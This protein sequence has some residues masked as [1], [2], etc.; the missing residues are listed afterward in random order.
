LLILS[1][2]SRR[3]WRPL[4]S[5]LRAHVEVVRADELEH[6]VVFDCAGLLLAE[7]VPVYQFWKEDLDFLESEVEANTHPLAS[8]KRNVCCLVSVLH[9]LS[10]PSVRIEARWVVPQRRIV[11]DVVYGW[12]HDGVFGNL[13][14]TGQDQIC[15]GSSA[16]LE[17]WVVSALCF[18]DV[19]VKER[20]LVGH[21]GSEFCVLVDAVVDQLLQKAFLHARIGDEAVD[22]PREQR[23]CCC[24]PSSR[25]DDKSFHQA[26]LRE[27]FSLTVSGSYGVI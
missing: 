16:R 8:S 7:L 2:S 4:G 12:D 25:S 1:Q 23:T 19:L 21:I 10:I 24:E 26:G 27:L 18:F 9:A 11:V 15:L 5:L 6:L 14:P 22:E 3:T 20:Q 17:T 13:V